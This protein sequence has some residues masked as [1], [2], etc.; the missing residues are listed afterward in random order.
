MRWNWDII[1]MKAT[2]LLD[3]PIYQMYLYCIYYNRFV[4]NTGY[5]Q[6]DAKIIRRVG[7]LEFSE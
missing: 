6:H 1:N 5:L 3:G 4:Q 2:L 7:T